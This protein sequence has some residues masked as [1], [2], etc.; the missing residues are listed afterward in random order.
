M[1]SDQKRPWPGRVETGR[2]AMIDVRLF[3]HSSA[4]ADIPDFACGPVG[5]NS[6]ADYVWTF[7][8]NSHR[9]EPAHILEDCDSR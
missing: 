8:P 6:Y 1:H 5:D 3:P 4:R 9:S 2:R 7:A